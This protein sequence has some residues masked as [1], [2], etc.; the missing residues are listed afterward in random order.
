MDIAIQKNCDLLSGNREKMKKVTFWEMNLVRLMGAL[1]YTMGEKEVDIEKYKEARKIL[2]Q[3]ASIFSSFRGIP[4]VLTISKMAMSDDPKAYF[5]SVKDVYTYMMKDKFFPSEDRVLASFSI[6]DNVEKDKWHEAVDKGLN[7]FRKMKEQHPLMTWEEDVSF[8]VLL[9]LSDADPD[10]VMDDIEDCYQEMKKESFFGR[11]NVQRLTQILGI[12]AM[13]KDEKCARVRELSEAF[14]KEHRNF[15]KGQ[16][17][18]ILAALA[19]MDMP[20]DEIVRKVIEADDN[21]KKKRGFGIFG[22]GKRMRQL[23]AA[24][25]VILANLNVKGADKKMMAATQGITMAIVEEIIL[26]III[27]C[28]ASSISTSISSGSSSGK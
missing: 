16:E 14:K 6:V 26:T 18:P 5:E 10:K 2:R 3:N 28:T 8:A 13:S 9:A 7:L 19:I 11:D 15:G 17:Y 25:M 24:S 23:F 4:K 21:L 1:A 22:T 27:V 20:V 12:S